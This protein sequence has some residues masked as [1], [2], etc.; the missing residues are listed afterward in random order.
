MEKIRKLVIGVRPVSKMFRLQSLS[1]LVIDTILSARGAKPFDDEYYSMI[2]TNNSIGSFRLFNNKL[3]NSLH[4]DESNVLFMKSAYECDTNLRPDKMLDEFSA[5][6]SLINKILKINDIRRIGIVGEHQIHIEK[7]NPSKILMGSLTNISVPQHPSKFHLK[8]EERRPTKEGLAPDIL[9]SDFI[10]INYDY[11]DSEIDVD[12]STIDS[13]NAN[14]DVQRYYS[15]LLSS[16]VAD[17]VKKLH[18]IFS[19]EKKKFD[20]HLK[21]RGICS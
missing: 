17:E 6:W 2:E 14:L 13:L 12:H 5:I 20:T 7:K 10:N 4:V 11:Y 16:N 15:P 3:G 9:K 21:E 19:E 8:Y 18:K 1:G